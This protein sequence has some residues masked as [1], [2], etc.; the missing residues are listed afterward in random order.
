[1]PT[2]SSKAVMPPPAAPTIAAALSSTPAPVK[3]LVPA[4]QMEAFKGFVLEFKTVTKIGLVDILSS[5][6]P[7]FTKAQ[8]KNTL[9]LVAEKPGKSQNWRIKNSP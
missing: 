5:K 9:E 6:F 8:V 7:D 2:K 3:K 1:M 4:D